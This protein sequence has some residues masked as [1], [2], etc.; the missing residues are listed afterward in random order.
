MNCH[1]PAKGNIK[2][3]SPLL[4]PVRDAWKTGRPVDWVRVHKLPDFA[5]FNHQIHVNRGVSCVS[6]HGRVDEMVEVRHDQPL[7][8]SWCLDCHRDP[9]LHR[10]PV[11]E[12]TNMK[13]VPPKDA[14]GLAA[15]LA[16]ERP[17]NPPVAC[18]GCHR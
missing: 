13:W 5:Y 14:Q 15:K 10:R 9:A 6:C 3:D 17:V 2:G 8:M 1:D 16:S 12:V 4:A 7:S 11:A 18:S